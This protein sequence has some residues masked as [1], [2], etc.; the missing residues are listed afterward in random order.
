MKEV[1]DPGH[2]CPLPHRIPSPHPCPHPHS[3]ATTP[4]PLASFSPQHRF[5]PPPPLPV[6][7]ATGSRRPAKASSGAG[8]EGRAFPKGP[9]ELSPFPKSKGKLNF[10]G[11]LPPHTTAKGK[12]PL[13]IKFYSI[14]FTRIA[15]PL[16]FT[17]IYIFLIF[18]SPPTCP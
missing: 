9:Q 2:P 14:Q 3:K 15:S 7:I 16:S 10:P 1:R 8:N 18:I 4:P 11:L 6:A 13:K 17:N 12:E 5:S